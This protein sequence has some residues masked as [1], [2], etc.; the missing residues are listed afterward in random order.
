METQSPTVAIVGAG[1]TGLLTAHGL[2]KAGFKVVLFDREAGL[3]ARTRDWPLSVHWALPTLK[4]L[5]SDS[6]LAK[7]PQA[8]CT[9]HV[10]YTPEIET[11]LCINGQSGEVMFR[12]QMPGM[13]RVTRQRLRRIMATE[14]APAIHWNKQLEKI[15][16]NGGGDGPVR[17]IFAD[18]TTVEADYV[19]GADGASSKVRELLFAG[20]DE[21]VAQAKPSGFMCATGYVTHHD[22]AKVEPVIK[23]HPIAAVT[24]GATSNCGVAV[25]YADDPDDMAKWTIAWIKIWRR[26]KLP[27]PPAHKGPEALAFI[28][29]TS[30]DVIDPFRSQIEWTRDSDPCYI[31]EMRTWEPVMWETH[32]RVTLAGDA[33]HPQLVTR[34]QGFQHAVLDAEQYVKALVS[35][36]DGGVDRQEALK[37][38][39]ADVVERGAKA[40]RQSLTEAELTM[41]L[42]SVG[43]TLM[44]KQGH[45][46]SA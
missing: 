36:R 29:A 38:Y 8:L 28:K 15:E 42:E 43:K 19:L 27:E 34:G 23:L 30:Q 45:A 25:M 22:A 46:R 35:V 33:A 2:K 10:E 40:V 9:P 1:L 37:T 31:D 17:L 41:D 16:F 14:F 3:D 11:M 20:G 39:T 5:L 21:E 6:A 32:G 13:R 44:A 18:G 26:G 24:V 7:F 12:S 4:A